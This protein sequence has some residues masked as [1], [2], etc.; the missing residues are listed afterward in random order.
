MK[1]RVRDRLGLSDSESKTARHIDENQLNTP[2]EVSDPH[3]HEDETKDSWRETLVK[4][5]WN[6]LAWGLLLVFASGLLIHWGFTYFYGFIGNPLVQAT[7]VIG[8]YTSAWVYIGFRWSRSKASK[9]DEYVQHSP[10]DDS[11]LLSYEGYLQ[12][13]PDGNLRFAL[14][15]GYRWF[16]LKAEP[17]R[18]RDVGYRS[19]PDEPVRILLDKRY[20]KYQPTSRGI[21][22]SQIAKGL[23]PHSSM[24]V[25]KSSRIETNE[26]F[27]NG[28]PPSFHDL[29][30]VKSC[31]PVPAPH[32]RQK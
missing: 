25:S 10:E 12:Q 32:S 31:F 1:G 6:A 8:T 17:L 2:E 27:D 3:T 20:V 16:G 19:R 28:S 30:S 5:R 11:P 4:Y 9:I 29:Q 13:S 22:V 26:R 7:I 24:R 15:K 23:N 14:I 21:K 18:R